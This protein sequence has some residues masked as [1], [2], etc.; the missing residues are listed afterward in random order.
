MGVN[1][2][3]GTE[4]QVSEQKE[5]VLE[6][7]LA[8]LRNRKWQA[9]LKNN[10]TTILVK[11][12]IGITAVVRHENRIETG[13]LTLDEVFYELQ[14]KA[15]FS[16][17]LPLVQFQ[18]FEQYPHSFNFSFDSYWWTFRPFPEC[19]EKERNN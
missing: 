6:S 13:H 2:M 19:G 5:Q 11:A 8:K 15:D 3:M 1:F 16:I 17:F 10:E 4:Y 18:N 14:G 9:V 12:E 7:A